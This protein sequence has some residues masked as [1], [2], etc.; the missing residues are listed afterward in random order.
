MAS[1][2]QFS[3]LGFRGSRQQS[4]KEQQAHTT[5]PVSPKKRK[6]D[7]DDALSAHDDISTLLQEIKN[8]TAQ[9]ASVTMGLSTANGF[10][11]DMQS[12]RSEMEE[13]KNGQLQITQ[14]MNTV[15]EALQAP[16]QETGGTSP[17]PGDSVFPRGIVQTPNRRA[18]QQ[19]AQGAQLSWANV[20]ESGA[21]SGWTTITNGKKKS[22]KHPRDQRCVLFGRN[23]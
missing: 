1:Q 20:M 6:V 14:L 16:R 18:K 3:T 7:I 15:M 10:L 8:A 19:A 13:I 5:R 22:K 2:F 11:Q 4:R 9:A 23:I 21:G 12:Y 17:P